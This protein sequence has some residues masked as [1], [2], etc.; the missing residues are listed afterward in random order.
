[1][2]NP[3]DLVAAWVAAFQSTPDLVAALG[4]E[5]G[6]GVQSYID[7]FPQSN[8]LRLAIQALKTGSLLVVYMGTGKARVGS[9]IQFSHRFSFIAKAP[10]GG[11]YGAIFNAFVNGVPDGGTLPLLRTEIHPACYPMDL[12]LPSSQRNSLLVSVDGTTLDY[13][14]FSAS[15]TETG[16]IG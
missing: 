9:A 14:E 7:A 16:A 10:I 11:S 13:F 3:D 6:A 12:D 5:N 4:G 15:L 2:L 1:M 8:N